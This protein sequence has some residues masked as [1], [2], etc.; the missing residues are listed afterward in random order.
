MW[1]LF[2]YR[3]FTAD[4]QREAQRDAARFRLAQAA[5]EGRRMNGTRSGSPDAGLGEAAP[6]WAILRALRRRA[7]TAFGP[8]SLR[9]EPAAVPRG[10]P[11]GCADQA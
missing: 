3:V 8:S 4:R 2:T 6:W 5:E 10:N 11:D 9:R 1:D 7:R